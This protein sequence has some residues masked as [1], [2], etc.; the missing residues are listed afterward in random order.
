MR[1]FNRNKRKLYLCH[2]NVSGKLVTY[3][4]PQLRYENYQPTNNDVDIIGVGMNYYNYLRIKTDIANKG[5]YH[6]G[7]RVYIDVPIPDVH[8]VLCK[9]ADYEVFKKPVSTPN[10]I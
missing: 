10:Y 7:D 1:T 9:Q 6:A 3:D 4:E 5:V 2:K 8:D